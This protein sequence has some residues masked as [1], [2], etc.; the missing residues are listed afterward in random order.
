MFLECRTCCPKRV[1]F[2]NHLLVLACATLRLVSAL[3]CPAEASAQGAELSA[4]WSRVTGDF[5]PDS[6]HLG[7][8][9][10]LS[11]SFAIVAEYD[12]AY[13]TSRVGKFEFT[14]V[15]AIAV[16]SHLQGFPIGPRFCFAH[17]KY[18]K[19]NSFG[20]AR[21]GAAHVHSTIQEGTLPTGN[22]FR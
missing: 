17:H 3:F 15:G 5:G 20:E 6:F 10:F 22:E 4:G 12:D 16:K 13:V 2:R 8:G 1:S 14:S 18:A 7:A 9:S 21:G 19:L 11:Q